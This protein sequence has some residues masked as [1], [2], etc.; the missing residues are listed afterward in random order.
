MKNKMFLVGA[1]ILAAAGVFAGDAVPAY[2]NFNMPRVE[3]MMFLVLQI[4][5]IIF[6]AKLG[7]VVASW[8][9]LP[10]ILGELAAG[11]VIGPWALGGIGF[12]EGVFQYGLFNGGALKALNQAAFGAN[13]SVAPIKAMFGTMAGNGTMFD[14]T[15]PALYGIATLAS[16]ILLFLSGLETNLKMFLKYSFVGLMVG[17]G[18]VIFSFVFGDLCAVY[19][20]PKFF[21]ARFAYLAQMPLSQ[22]W[23]D[24]A[25]MYMGIMSTATSVGITARILSERKKMDS[26]EGVSI[27]AGAVIDDVLGLIVLA[28]GNGI[29]AATIAAKSSATGAS[30]GVQW[31]AIGMVAVKAFAVWLGA[32]L[33]GVLAA[34]KI[35]WL[36]KLFKNPQA[37]ATLAFGLALILAGFFEYMG[38]AMIIGAYV[39]GLALSRTDLKHM[40]QEVLAPVYTFLV[41]VFFCVMGMMVDCTALMSKPVIYFGLIYTVLAVFAKVIGCALPSLFCGFNILGSLR[42]GAGMVPRGEVALIIAGLGLSSGYLSQEIFG[43]GILMTLITTVIAPPALI[44]LFM[45]QARGVRHPKESMVDSRQVVFDLPD[46]Q[47]AKIML[48][49]LVNEFRRE[50]F[51]AIQ[52]AH[53]VNMAIWE[54]SMNE[55]ELTFQ[56]V[57][58]QIRVECNPAEEAVVSQA[59]ME[60]VSQ[61][62]LLSKVISQPVMKKKNMKELIKKTE[63]EQTGKSTEANGIVQNFAMLPA[64]KAHSKKEAIEKLC[65][66]VQEKFPT[67]VKDIQ[68]V[69]EA[70]LMREESMPTGLDNGIAVPHGRTDG[71]NHI[72]GAVA[73]VDNSENEN[74]IIPDWETIDHSKIQIIV[75]TLVPES[76]PGPYLQVMAYISRVIHSNDGVEALLACKTEEEMRAFFR[77]AR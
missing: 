3:E 14:A 45:P 43:I 16:V 68:A 13:G 72:V 71:V 60:V 11:I 32:T 40:I 74:G 26:E 25:P 75:L 33:V 21:A 36:L 67:T 22:A 62:N 51:Y 15:S 12:G 70:V 6:A 65:E 7:G 56:R 66:I 24:A 69:K 50:G 52:Y 20:L 57:G 9:K 31:G 1:A 73:V 30:A 44:A 23:M 54:V 8:M 46:S 41:P 37:I 18:G 59:W 28:I 76:T 39:T 42:I 17:I 4:G 63:T 77:K 34:R 58:S 10:S 19:L 48:R 47:V 2:P 29:I 61:I 5:I 27:M 53:E 49:K 35:S 64:F 38:L 55:M